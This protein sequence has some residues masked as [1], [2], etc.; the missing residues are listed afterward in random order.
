MSQNPV[1]TPEQSSE[2]NPAPIP[3]TINGIQLDPNAPAVRAL[4][5][6]IGDAANTKY[7]LVQTKGDLDKDK[8]KILQDLKVELEELISDRTYLCRFVP[9]DLDAVRGLDFVTWASAYGSQFVVAPDL[10]SNPSTASVGPGAAV[11]QSTSQA[12]EVDV[13]FHEN[14]E[15]QKDELISAVARAARVQPEAQKGGRD[16]VRLLVQDRY[17]S[18]VAR[19]DE[20]RAILPVV[21]N[22]LYNDVA[23]NI[24]MGK[25]DVAT[26]NDLMYGNNKL[27]G[28]EEIVAVADTGIDSNHVAFTG[29]ILR[30]VAWGRTGQ[31]G[32]PGKTDDP[33][34][35]GT[36]VSGSVLG[37]GTYS[38]SAGEKHQ[39]QGTAPEAKLFM[40][41]VLDDEG[42]L[43]G[44]PNNVSKLFDE[45]YKSGARV[46]TNSWGPT[47]S[48]LA[49]TTGDSGPQIDKFVR[50][51]PDMVICFAAGNEGIDAD[52]NGI[53]D[54][55]QIGMY[56]AAKNNITVGAS[57]N[58]RPENGLDY[59]KFGYQGLP[60]RSDVTANNSMGMAAF[61]NRGPSK[62]GRIKPDVVAPGT[63]ILSA[64]SSLAVA[65]T[66]W[67][68]SD[69]PKWMFEGGTSM[70]TPL[71]A[72]GC[73]II[74]Q[75]LKATKPNPSAALVKALLI[76]GAV[77][78]KGQYLPSE[79]GP[80]PN[81]SSGWGRV[82]LDESVQMAAYASE[83]AALG[84]FEGA[85]L[86]DDGSYTRDVE[87]KESSKTLKVTLVWTDLAGALLQND[88]ALSVAVAGA[89]RQGNPT[90][91]RKNNVEQIVW[92]N[93]PSGTAKVAVNVK[94]L[95]RDGQ[96]FALA[97]KVY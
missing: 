7:V 83:P 69:D 54:F 78:L 12:H 60:L 75:A 52:R 88:L 20:V 49:Y 64:K 63:C 2:Q 57:E 1:T 82:N 74:R 85:P 95:I 73:A 66:T 27:R 50:N 18:D 61:S 28:K 43:G 79:A 37:D 42:N 65:G 33:D 36:H 48:G 72:G 51:H 8:K 87:I 89:T 91:S 53:V 10:R 70:A 96:D 26:D 39:V 6:G 24:L 94:R 76:N 77:E 90:S 13:V 62:E 58:F 5:L 93:I 16:K 34:G 25:G 35:H 23:R 92:T 45:A 15:K 97:W 21:Q 71:V 40:Q 44:L 41:S 81:F 31:N 19:L 9:N 38:T 22:K 32:A 84:C 80:S 59:G 56:A 11:A 3:I 30:E 86:E 47:T 67:G 46:H 17:F 4:G 29:R 55:K 14:H 68:R